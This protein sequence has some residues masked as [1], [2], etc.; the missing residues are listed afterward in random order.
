MLDLCMFDVRKVLFYDWIAADIKGRFW[1]WFGRLSIVERQLLGVMRAEASVWPLSSYLLTF[2]GKYSCTQDFA[3]LSLQ[4]IVCVANKNT[5]TSLWV[6]YCHWSHF[7]F[8]MAWCFGAIIWSSS[9]TVHM[10]LWMF[11]SQSKKI[12]QVILRLMFTFK[13]TL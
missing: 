12:K 6:T 4:Y 11:L 8:F 7:F 13:V 9:N 2:Q 1:V 10:I 3:S 5:C